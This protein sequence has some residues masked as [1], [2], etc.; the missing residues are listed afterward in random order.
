[1]FNK[2]LVN[3]VRKLVEQGK[4]KAIG[5][6]SIDMLSHGFTKDLIIKSFL[7]GII[8]EDKELYPEDPNKKHPK[9]NYYCIHSYSVDLILSRNILISFYIKENVLF[10]HTSPLNTNAEEHRFYKKYIKKFKELFP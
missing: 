7:N 1:M 4:I 3:K 5:N 9:K 2:E 10:F 6:G 8:L